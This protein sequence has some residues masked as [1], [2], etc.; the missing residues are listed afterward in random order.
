MAKRRGDSF[1]QPAPFG[2]PADEDATELGCSQSGIIPAG[3][4]AGFHVYSAIRCLL[5]RRVKL[6][7]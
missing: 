6:V 3:E 4:E 7:V 2:L 5:P 1:I